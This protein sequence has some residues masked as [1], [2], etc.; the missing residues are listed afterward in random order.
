MKRMVVGLLALVLA[1]TLVFSGGVSEKTVAK[2]GN[3]LKVFVPQSPGIPQGV[4]ALAKAYM[5]KNPG[6]VVSVRNVPFA[7]YKDQ[8]KIMWSSENVDD[9]VMFAPVE[10]P[11]YAYL[12][13]L[14]PLDDILP[15][16]E[17]KLFIPSVIEAA[18]FEDHIYSYP[19]K[20]SCS[21]MFYN[22]DYFALAGIEPAT[23][24]TPWTW[25]EWKGN[26]L[27]ARETVAKKTGKTPWGLTF[28][29][30]PGVGDFWVTP[31]IRSNGTKDSNTYKAISSDGMTLTGYADTAEAMEAYK[32]YQD[33]YQVDKLSPIAE[34]PDAFATGQ[35]ITFISFLST[36]SELEKKFPDLNWGLMPLPYFKTPLTHTSGFA[37]SISAKTKVPTLAKDFVKFA[38]SEEGLVLFS[39][40]SGSDIVSR[41]DFADKHPELYAKAYQQFFVKNLAKY[42]EARPNTPGYALYNAIIGFSMFQDIIAGA[43]I[44]KTVKDKIKIFE[45]QMKIF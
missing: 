33:L 41:L 42:G 22:K 45:S 32:F 3:E 1:C 16:S 37:L 12:G 9:V 26:I 5:E 27:K 15:E 28:I 10:A 19:L 24:E 6:T 21:A 30:N 17:K 2:E 38:G 23:L 36:A 20:E 34:V 14:L 43:D 39:K 29:V 40:I 44:E 18:T 7:Q 8:L 11:T 31:I 35:S 13:S 4:E 25:P